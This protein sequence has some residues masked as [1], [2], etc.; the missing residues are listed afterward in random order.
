MTIIERQNRII[1][2]V[3]NTQSDELLQQVES[4]LNHNE[5]IGYEADGKPIYKDNYMNEMD[6]IMAEIENGTAEK[7]SHKDVMTKIKNAFNLE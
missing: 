5:I 4:L 2:S 1:K 3:L 7:I 6:K